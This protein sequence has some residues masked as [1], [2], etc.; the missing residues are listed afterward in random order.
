MH[1]VAVTGWGVVSPWGNDPL[2]FRES[3]FSGQSAIRP[4]SQRTDQPWP[5][6]TAAWIDD[7]DPRAHFSVS[8]LSTLD[9]TSQF[10]MVSSR[11]ALNMSGLDINQLNLEQCGVYVGTGM[12]SAGAL[13]TTYSSFYGEQ[14]R[15]LKPLTVPMVMSNSAAAHIAIE[16]G[17]LGGNVTFCS[18]CASSGI[19]IG[20]ASRKIR[21][22]E[23]KVMLAGG[24]E[25]LIYPGVLFAWEA[26]RTLA[27]TD[28]AD[29][30]RSCKPFSK[31]RTGMVLGEGSAFFVLESWEHA[32][33]R[34]ANIL[35][36]LIGFSS[37][38]DSG[39]LTKPSI[40]GQARAMRAALTD[41]HLNSDQIG[42]I[43]AHGTGTQANDSAEA[44]AIQEVF[45]VDT[46][47]VPVSS[48]KA[49]HGHLLG[50]ASAM[51]LLITLMALQESVVP[52]TAN[53]DE[54]DP[55]C[56]LDH[57]MGHPKPIHALRYAMSNSFAFGGTSSVLIAKAAN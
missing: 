18:A 11:S 20:E 47:T 34:G 37:T 56:H 25:S 19:A 30:A 48:S 5:D 42:Y 13:E 4:L 45:G 10:A 57:V 50:A 9:R 54:I 22:G 52:P 26:L 17:F 12:G 35:A 29:P 36:E 16:T 8:Q 14:N 1:R 23:A 41:A 2:R 33:K 15:R 51:E 46:A 53:L 27:E 49:V 21:Y 7:F 31:N 40:A 32:E 3:V 28:Q 39:H 43:N 44:S 24:A 6:R 55:E 38:S